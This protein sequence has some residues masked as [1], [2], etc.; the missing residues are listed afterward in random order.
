MATK[1]I[2]CGCPHEGQDKLYGKGKRLANKRDKAGE[3]KCTVCGKIHK[4]N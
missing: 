2:M 3:Y 1:E 4:S